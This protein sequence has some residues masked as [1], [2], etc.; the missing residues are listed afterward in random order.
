MPISQGRSGVKIRAA[1]A[2]P[3][4]TRNVPT[5]R[6]QALAA[7]RLAMAAIDDTTGPRPCT[8]TY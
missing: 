1:P 8:V 5:G 4:A 3:A 7:A 2:E 6:Q